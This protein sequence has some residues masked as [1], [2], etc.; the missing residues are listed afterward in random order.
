[1]KKRWILYSTWEYVRQPWVVDPINHEEVFDNPIDAFRQLW[2]YEANYPTF[3][4]G[5]VEEE[6]INPPTTI[7]LPYQGKTQWVLYYTISFYTAVNC[8]S[9]EVF[10]TKEEATALKEMLL[11]AY[12]CITMIEEPVL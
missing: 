10:A 4:C 3:E 11:P 2:K 5:R 8:N 6:I 12:E 1:M 9:Q 7:Q